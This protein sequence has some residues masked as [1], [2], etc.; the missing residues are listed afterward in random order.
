MNYGLLL[1]S[2]IYYLT[3]I[4]FILTIYLKSKI[5]PLNMFILLGSIYYLHIKTN[6]YDRFQ[7]NIPKNILIIHDIICHWGPFIYTLDKLKND[8]IDWFIVFIVFIVYLILAI[9]H[10]NNIYFNVNKF[11]LI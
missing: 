5:F 7:K 11:Y 1:K 8:K 4:V 6:F 10:L 9:K 3:N 2:Q